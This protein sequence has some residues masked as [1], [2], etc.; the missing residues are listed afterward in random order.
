VIADKASKK[1]AKLG[2]ISS[3]LI[4][5]KGDTRARMLKGG[6]FTRRIKEGLGV[7]AKGREVFGD[8]D[9]FYR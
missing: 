9:V 1:E 3:F 5:K 8:G 7:R 6:E 4:A 2:G